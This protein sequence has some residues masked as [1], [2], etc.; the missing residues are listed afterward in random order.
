MLILNERGILFCAY[1]DTS[2][3]EI[4]FKNIKQLNERL[5]NKGTGA[6]SARGPRQV[7]VVVAART[8]SEPP[9]RQGR[10]GRQG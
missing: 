3:S 6:V 4:E 9:K 5:K 2:M 8:K 7:A 10:Q 1:R